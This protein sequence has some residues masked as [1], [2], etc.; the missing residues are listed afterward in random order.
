M[1]ITK[2]SPAKDINNYLFSLW[3]FK[4][5]D[6]GRKRRQEELLKPFPSSFKN[7][8]RKAKTEKE[9]RE[10]IKNYFASLPQEFWRSIERLK[11]G[12]QRNLDK[13]EPKIISLL[14][15]VYQKPF[16]FKRITVYITTIPICPYNFKQRWLAVFKN[17][18]PKE[19]IN[20]VIHELNHFMFYFYFS[21]LKEKLGEEKF[22]DLK[23][24]LTVLTNPEEKGYP[25]HRK[26][27]AFIQKYHYL[28]L[29]KIISLVFKKKTGFETK[30][31]LG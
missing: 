16:P 8:L 1:F 14:E 26:L 18:S 21:P 22:E 15:R 20:I 11:K 3:Q 12:L 17:A 31:S 19:H 30:S 27:R 9:A 5:R 10:V 25:A 2:Y 29:E 24:A 28:P 4:R 13:N 6:Y 23:E 7:A